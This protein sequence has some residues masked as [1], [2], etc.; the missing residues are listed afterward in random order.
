MRIIPAT[1]IKRRVTTNFQCTHRTGTRQNAAPFST[2]TSA[3]IARHYLFEVWKQA[4]QYRCKSCR[5]SLS[6]RLLHSRTNLA[7]ALA[8]REQYIESPCSFEKV[9]NSQDLELDSFFK[10]SLH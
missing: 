9:V 6:T 2:A 10:L 8:V 7:L 5:V 3:A 1:A 4:L